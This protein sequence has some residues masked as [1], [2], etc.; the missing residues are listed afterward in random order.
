MDGLK[1]E[2]IK[3]FLSAL[4]F[5]GRCPIS[6]AAIPAENGR[7]MSP[8]TEN[9]GKNHW[10]RLWEREGERDERKINELFVLGAKQEMEENHREGENEG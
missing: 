4:G 9:L 5:H 6:S 10:E 7:N 2:N 1:I 3:V 8:Q